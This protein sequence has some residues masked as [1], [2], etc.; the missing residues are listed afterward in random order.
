[1]TTTL[2][3]R[4]KSLA[5][6]SAMMGVAFAISQIAN[7]LTSLNLDP[8]LTVFLGLVLAQVSKFLNTQAS[9]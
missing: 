7:G 1:M 3:K 9:K 5:W 4:I 2:Q 6:S 8:S